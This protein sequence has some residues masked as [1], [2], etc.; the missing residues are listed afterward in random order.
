MNYMNSSM[1][2]RLPPL[3]ALRAFEAAARNGSFKLAAAELAVTPTAIS[4]QIRSL[5]DHISLALFERRTRKV[6]LTDVGAALYP[7][8]RD[9]L[10]GFAAAVDR[11]TRRATRAQ[12]T[13]SATIAFTARWLVPRVSR[14]QALHPEIDLR[15][16]AS[17][18]VVDMA[19]GSVDIAIR[20]GQGRY[21]GP[22]ADL[23][24]ADTFGP[25]VNPLLGVTTPADFGKVPLIEFQWRRHHP[26]NPTWERWFTSAGLD[27]PPCPATLRSS[28]ESHAIQSAMAGQGIALV[29]LALVAEDLAAGRL[30]QPFDTVLPGHKHNLLLAQ[31]PSSSA[32][33]AAEWLRSE[34]Q[35]LLSP[36]IA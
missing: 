28:D 33:A 23:L 22:A 13:I 8:L 34:A 1:P 10:D 17:D 7:V 26:A 25:V 29:S 15:L 30:V 4:H 24:L 6:E 32:I 3:S 36:V 21:E 11:L 9:G 12:V 16:Q 2:R 31:A 5:E 18:E 20:Y 27:Q 14:F 19:R 35:N